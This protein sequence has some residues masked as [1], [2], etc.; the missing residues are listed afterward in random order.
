MLG[1]VL[2]RD[3]PHERNPSSDVWLTITGPLPVILVNVASKRLSVCVSGL[4]STLTGWFV[5][6]AFKW[7]RKGVV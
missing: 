3:A 5:N 1:E 6:V 4:E 2:R 7:V